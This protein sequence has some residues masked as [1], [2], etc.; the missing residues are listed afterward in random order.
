M[1]MQKPIFY[2]TILLALSAG[3]CDTVTFISVDNLFSAHVTG[4]FIVFAYDI[5]KHADTDSWLKLLS[6][7]VF[8][9]A[10]ICGG[11]IAA[12]SR[13]SVAI[14]VIE[15]MVLTASGISWIVFSMAGLDSH[16]WVSLSVAMCVVFSMG[17]QNAFGKIFSKETYGPTTMMTGNVTQAALDLGKLVKNGAGDLATAGSL[18]NQ[19]IT[20]SGFL[21]GCLLGAVLGKIFG[22]AAVLLPGLAITIY[23]ISKQELGPADNH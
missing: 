4:N 16:Q 2:L 20:I 8:I 17:L 23:A 19:A 5:L 13:S 21:V 7:P 15:G 12:G 9:I 11:N 14:L 22:L 6:F 3:Y 18:R 10:V 1:E